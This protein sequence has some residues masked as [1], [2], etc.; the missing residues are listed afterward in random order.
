MLGLE[1]TL[2][3]AVRLNQNRKAK[4]QQ[5]TIFH[6]RILTRAALKYIQFCAF[7]TDKELFLLCYILYIPNES[8]GNIYIYN[9][10]E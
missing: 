6:V 10:D 7:L 8:I 5:T 2:R 4:Q 9:F 3:R 1:T